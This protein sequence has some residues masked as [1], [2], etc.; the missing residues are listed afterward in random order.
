VFEYFLVFLLLLSSSFILLWS[1][2]EWGVISTFLYLIR[3]A[4]STKICLILE[5]AQWAGEKNVYCAA[6][7]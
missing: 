2:R 5:K 1:D 7:G 3:L 6:A 4:L